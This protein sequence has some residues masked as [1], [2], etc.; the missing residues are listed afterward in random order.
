MIKESLIEAL[1]LTSLDYSKE[2]MIFSFS[3]KD[4]IVVVLL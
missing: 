1:V 2:F 4:T 3:S